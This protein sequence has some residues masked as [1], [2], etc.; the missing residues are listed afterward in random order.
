MQT[1][2]PKWLLHNLDQEYHQSLTQNLTTDQ[3]NQL[4]EKVTTEGGVSQRT[5]VVVPQR[6]GVVVP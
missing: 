4:R 3:T 2:Q 1:A 6:I 5:T